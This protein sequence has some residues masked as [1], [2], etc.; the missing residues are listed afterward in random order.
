M[1][2]RL[3]VFGSR[4]LTARHHAVMR[5]FILAEALYLSRGDRAAPIPVERILAA[6]SSDDIAG[7]VPDDAR[8]HDGVLWLVHG[9]GPP[10]RPPGAIGAD[11]LAEVAAS[12]EWPETRRVK[13]FPP[14]QQ[15]GETWAQAA[16]R[17]NR[18]MVD[19]KPDRA[20]CFHENLDMSKG[21]A[22]TADFLQR[23]GVRFRYVR[24]TSAGA[25][26][27]VEDR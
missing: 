21:S 24:L 26:V 23:A 4:N 1:T 10:G 5:R 19:A 27:S 14:V 9:D 11:K 8:F 12:L 18:A 13:R 15:D 3:L 6:Q 22:M 20:L 17:R 16:A 2:L 25:V 7:L